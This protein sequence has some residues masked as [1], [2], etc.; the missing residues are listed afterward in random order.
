MSSVVNE[1]AHSLPAYDATR[2]ATRLRDDI[3]K[4]DTLKETRPKPKKFAFGS[5]NKKPVSKEQVVEEPV[6]PKVTEMLA[7]PSADLADL[8]GETRRF[9][10]EVN[11]SDVLFT[12][13]THCTVYVSVLYFTIHEICSDNGLSIDPARVALEVVHD[14]LRARLHVGVHRQLHR[15]HVRVRRATDAHARECECELTTI[16]WGL[17]N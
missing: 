6:A 3:A 4:L 16:T 12:R 8:T 13:L 2:A 10:D 11:K 1:H 5:R 15:V 9:G 14:N 7:G 17:I